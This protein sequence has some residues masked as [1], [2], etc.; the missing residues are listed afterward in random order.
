[1]L[2]WCASPRRADFGVTRT[3]HPETHGSG[4][5]DMRLLC[6]VL[7]AAF[8][9]SCAIKEA[10]TGSRR[11]APGADML[12]Q[13]PEQVIFS[14]GRPAATLQVQPGSRLVFVRGPFGRHSYFVDFDQAGRM[15]AFEQVLTRERFARIHPGMSGQEV[16]AIIGPSTDIRGLAFKRVLWSWR[17]ENYECLWFQVELEASG[18]V[19]SAGNAI[20]PECQGRFR[21]SGV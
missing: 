6:L 3:V 15:S 14:L 7:L 18:V 1:V 8:L 10:V 11:Y 13:T 21:I 17:F 19:R 4:S 2:T 12:G 9:A 5:S 20:S 16:I